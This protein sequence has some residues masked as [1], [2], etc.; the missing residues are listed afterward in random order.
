[1]GPPP[2]HPVPR[3]G[4]VQERLVH[5]DVDWSEDRGALDGDAGGPAVEMHGLPRPGPR[6]LWEH[7]QG[8][9]GRQRGNGLP[10]HGVGRGVADV[11]SRPY[12]QACEGIVENSH[13]DYAGGRRGEGDDEHD[14]DQGRVIGD[15]QLPRASKAFTTLEIVTEATGS[16]HDRHE[17][18]EGTLD[19]APRAGTTAG[20]ATWPEQHHRKHHQT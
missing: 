14:V 12:N 2:W 1:M 16:A 15:D 17:R 7:D 20:R 5:A 19:E 6:P 8:I 10:D 9:A 4:L 11:A 18:A 13:L 3:L